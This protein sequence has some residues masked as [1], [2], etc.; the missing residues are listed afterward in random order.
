MNDR[1]LSLRNVTRAFNSVCA[2][3]GIT[4]DVA[5]NEFVA[6][7]GPSGCGKTTLLNLLSGHDQ[8]TGGSVARQG[9]VRMIYQQDGLFPWATVAENILLG[10]HNGTDA[11]L[12][13]EQLRD[14]LALIRLDAFANH[15]PHQ[16]SG[17]MRQLVE[18]ARAMAG[19]V[20]ILLMDEPFSS[21]DY[22]ARLRMRHELTRMLAER[23]RTV[24]FVTHDIEEAAQLADRVV[25]L[26]DRP[27]RVRCEMRLEL[28][29][30]RPP[31]HPAVTDV[32]RRA[33]RE[34][35]LEQQEDDVKRTLS[36]A[37]ELVGNKQ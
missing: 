8:P 4:L 24:V 13:Q 34:M 25:V 1:S 36:I 23:P 27:G 22:L 33:L 35:G 10:L 37:S 14:L 7:V 3:D 26:S 6:I 9:E 28:P 29:R 31:T 15:Y 11:A 16:L 20:R 18:L 2:L 32:V 21:L 17:G 12:R 30:P 5:R 19:N